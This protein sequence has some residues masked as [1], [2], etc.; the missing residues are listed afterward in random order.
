MTDTLNAN[1]DL[2]VIGSVS[3][4]DGHSRL[5]MQADGN[6]VLYRAG[7]Q[8]RWA[9]GT[10]GKAV[11]Q[12]VMQGDGNFV[13][14][15]PGG[16]YI[17]D[18]GTHGHPGAR[19]VIQDDGNVVIYGTDGSPLWATNTWIARRTVGGFLP[20]TSGLHFPNSFPHV[21]HFN[22]DVLGLQVPIGDAAR[23]LCGG[24]V[25]TT[26]DYF[27]AGSPPPADTTAPSSGPLYDH[28]VKRLYDSFSLP[29]GPTIYLDLMNP[30]RPDH[31]T[32]LSR[33][34]FAPHGRAWVMINEAWPQIRAD[35]DSNRLSPLGL[36]TVK[37]MDPLRLGENHQVLAYGY[38]LDG[39]ALS[40]RIY[41]PNYPNNDGLTLS[42]DIGDPQH[43]TPVTYSGNLGGDK[44][45]WCFFRTHYTHATP[46]G[47]A[48]APQWHGWESLGG[49][50]SSG[51]DVSSW[52]AGR[53]DVFLRGTDNAL[54]HKWYDGA[55]SGWEHQGGVLTSDPTAVSWG[56]GRID[57]FARGTDN[58]LHHKWYDGAWSGWESL[59]GLLTSG[60]DVASWG[61]GRLDVFV[62]GTDNALWHK[63]YEGGWSDWESLGGVL[64]SDPAVV[65]W[66]NGRIDVFVRGTDNALHHKWYEGGWS[67]WESLGGVLSSAPDVSSW[68][69]GRLDVFARG[70]DNA[71]WHKWYEGGW[72]G[73]E[74]LGGALTSDPS[75]VSWGGGRIDVFARGTDNALWH[76]WYG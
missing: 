65:S 7:G 17:W 38:E 23:G 41:D 54:Y 21:P 14:Y 59:G 62:R 9:T 1:Q 60:P 10:D 3:S 12:A 64:A 73:W 5:V 45:V 70:T 74:S 2:A 4:Q 43:T 63:W 75:A 18:T 29:L 40:M 34:G 72:S 61:A 33:I 25:F 27:E 67:S 30:G 69:P 47:L 16:T 31:E 68:A 56:P 24:M 52:A 58:A 20:S 53:L 48:A 50:L 39:T 71:L 32:D 49:V 42:L 35:L 66:R 6:L 8:P 44:V 22:I 37:S 55:W 51:P 36:V 28:L 15:G 26:R 76:R 13:M 19:L 46:P 11:S 57:V